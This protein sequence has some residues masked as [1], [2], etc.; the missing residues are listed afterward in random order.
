MTALLS[1]DWLR[2]L[3]VVRIDTNDDQEAQCHA[4]NLHWPL[5]NPS[6]CL[7][8]VQKMARGLHLWVGARCCPISC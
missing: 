5:A 3:F 6:D 2:M 8:Q 1:V 4:L 7:M